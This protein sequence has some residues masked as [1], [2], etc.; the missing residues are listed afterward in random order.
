MFVRV[1]EKYRNLNFELAD[2]LTLAAV[3]GI[4]LGLCMSKCSIP[5]MSDKG[6]TP[7][8]YD[9]VGDRFIPN[10]SATQF[11]LGHFLLTNR[12]ASADP[13]LSPTRQQY[14]QAM[15]GSLNGDLANSKIIS[16]SQ[17]PPQIG[18]GACLLLL[19]LLG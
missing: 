17:R 15:C 12:S 6:G 11:E 14:Q 10:R 7:G 9:R 5:L 4:R 3:Y 19:L 18:D 1:R 16:Y 13:L 8:R 2:L